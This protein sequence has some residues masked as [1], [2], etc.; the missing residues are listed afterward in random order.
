[1]NKLS[2]IRSEVML[3]YADC[4]RGWDKGKKIRNL[5]YR[6]SKSIDKNSAIKL[7]TEA[8]GA[9]SPDEAGYNNFCPT[10]LNRLPDDSKVWIAREGSVCIYVETKVD[11]DEMKLCKL[12]H[13]D[14]VDIDT[15]DHIRIWWD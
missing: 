9:D 7:L 8:L 5:S 11:I 12:L 6:S 15:N 4:N 2:G 1:M 13:A 10:L 3:A 14:E